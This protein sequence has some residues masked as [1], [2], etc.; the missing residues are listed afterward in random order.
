MVNNSHKRK[1]T[2]IPYQEYIRDL[3]DYILNENS[4]NNIEVKHNHEIQGKTYPHKI[5]V[6][7]EFEVGDLTYRTIV[8][9]KDWETPVPKERVLTFKAII[10][11]LPAGTHGIMISRNG[12][13]IG[14]KTIAEANGIVLYTLRQPTKNDFENDIGSKK[15][16]FEIN[17]PL[18]DE[19]KLFCSREGIDPCGIDFNDLSN[20]T[21]NIHLY[22]K[23]NDT[24]S[25]VCS[26]SELVYSY[27]FSVGKGREY[28]NETFDDF[29]ITD[30]NQSY[31][32]IERLSGYFGLLQPDEFIEL[33]AK[34]LVGS[35]LKD[36]FS[37]KIR[38]ITKSGR[39]INDSEWE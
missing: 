18:V 31:I 8:E 27:C 22:K 23:T 36:I 29:Y 7:W 9:A 32:R 24:F 26:L 5:D 30:K 1:N 2:G 25:P 37:G 11:D 39:V 4:V 6:Y 17:K 38:T 3:Y 13:Q 20:H 28:I 35:Y 14:A 15:I 12:F 19:L 34:D 33:K 10:D 21:P 16:R